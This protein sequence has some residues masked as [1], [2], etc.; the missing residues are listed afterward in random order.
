MQASEPYYTR[1]RVISAT[2]KFM[3]TA[4]QWDTVDKIKTHT[5]KII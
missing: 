2:T 5:V 3:A 4:D 1:D